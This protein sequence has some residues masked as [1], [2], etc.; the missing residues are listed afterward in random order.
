MKPKEIITN[1]QI[2]EQKLDE[3][4][5]L[6]IGAL[7][8]TAAGATLGDYI[9][10]KR[11]GD[12]DWSL[13]QSIDR[14][15]Q[16]GKNLYKKEIEPAAEKLAKDIHKGVTGKDSDDEEK[17]KEEK[18]ATGQSADSK[19]TD[20]VVPPGPY[21]WKDVP[22]LHG[23]APGTKFKRDELYE[24]SLDK[25]L[26]KYNN[27]LNE[28]EPQ[29]N[30]FELE[31]EK[32]FTDPRTRSAIMAKAR[33]ESGAK[34]VGEL[35][36]AKNTNDHIRTVFKG[37]PAIE[38]LSDAELS[39]LKKNPVAFYDAT[40]KHLGG[41]KYRGRGPIQITGKDNYAR[42]DRELGLNGALVKDPDLLLRDPQL[43]NAASIQYLKNAGLH[44]KTY[45]NQR[46]AHLDVIYAI[47][48]PSY[49]PGSWRSN[50]VYSQLVKD[51]GLPPKTTATQAP[52]AEPDSGTLAQRLRKFV[53]LD[54]TEVPPAK[55]A[56]KDQPSTKTTT[57]ALD[58]PTIRTTASSTM[59]TTIDKTEPIGPTY[60]QLVNVPPGKTFSDVFD[61][62]AYTKSKEPMGLTKFIKPVAK[63][64]VKEG[65]AHNKNHKYKNGS[66]SRQMKNKKVIEA[67]AASTLDNFMGKGKDIASTTG[68]GAMATQ[69]PRVPGLVKKIG[70]KAIP[71]AN[72][73]YQAADAAE[74][75]KMGDPVGAAIAGASAVPVLAIPGIAAQSIRD[76]ARTGSFF[77]D[78]EELAKAAAQDQAKGGY[79]KARA[80]EY[81]PSF[82]P[83]NTQMQR[84]T[85]LRLSVIKEELNLKKCSM[86]EEQIK[87]KFFYYYDGK[88]TIFNE[89]GM[90]IGHV[91]PQGQVIITEAG[92]PPWAKD[93]GPKLKQGWDWISTNVPPAYR[94]G[95]EVVGK[96]ADE[97]A[98]LYQAGKGAA[99]A[100]G[101]EI[102][103]VPTS[104]AKKLKTAYQDIKYDI[105][106]GLSSSERLAHISDKRS[107]DAVALIDKAEAE[108]A[109]R[110]AKGLATADIEQ[111]KAKALAAKA[112]AENLKQQARVTKAGADIAAG[113]VPLVSP[114]SK[115]MGKIVGGTGLTL[116]GVDVGL[117][118][119]PE[120][121]TIPGGYGVGKGFK[122]LVTPQTPASTNESVLQR[123]YKQFKLTEQ[124]AK[125]SETLAQKIRRI[126]GLDQPEVKPAPP[127]TEPPKTEPP[128]T[129]PPKTEPPKTEPPKTEPPKTEPPKTEPPKTEPPKTEPPKTEPPKTEPPKTDS[130][131]DKVRAMQQKLR[132]SGYG[133]LLG[134]FG[135][136]G[137]GVDGKWGKFT[138]RA[139]DSY[140]ADK[141]AKQAALND[142][143]RD[144]YDPKRDPTIKYT[145]LLDPIDRLGGKAIAPTVPAKAYLDTAP[146]LSKIRYADSEDTIQ[147]ILKDKGAVSESK[148]TVF[149]RDLKTILKLAGRQ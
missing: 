18:T 126:A 73:A 108:A 148:D 109:A 107:R 75:A 15:I 30:A 27:F 70:A 140:M 21:P 41:Y 102:V 80:S 37:N 125:S 142:P 44:K 16:R 46:D 110:R 38:R 11:K 57:T 139:Y 97:L 54:K 118:Y 129:E 143:T 83:E 49:K 12:K 63:D 51:E 6:L 136:E 87:E 79:W 66:G 144:P 55:T 2:E 146:D 84:L 119:D 90:I 105:P 124:E 5:P 22:G 8:G 113:E 128:K 20:I 60:T 89:D 45:S 48:G 123:K 36:Y 77:P 95:K 94:K 25:V 115:Q 68:L 116:G 14:N 93:I 1:A 3:F 43:A 111:A 114:R 64:T 88:K 121:G 33:Q 141:Q 4:F 127:K 85:N 137:D 52:A 59:P 61:I 106:P 76:K 147:Q 91:S 17:E 9:L 117:Q 100:V 81:D 31:V 53:G 58:E 7:G 134:K 67:G 42:I 132:D 19:D 65:L 133:K 149:D 101:K 74:R 99:T 47:G 112:E 122:Q 104:A 135:P 120:S 10:Q 130:G 29:K 26:T 40:Y 32:H 39:A 24:K 78:K 98:S 35:S 96:T 56:T 69:L 71:I 34:N 13:G 92:I 86:T 82:L 145:E 50:K 23:F 62:D 28:K 138:Q 72:I 131:S 103:D